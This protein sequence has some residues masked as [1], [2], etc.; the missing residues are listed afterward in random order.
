MAPNGGGSPNLDQRISVQRKSQ[1]P[2]GGGGSTTTWIADGGL[3]AAIEEVRGQERVIADRQAG[4]VTYRVTVH[5]TGLGAEI[6][7][8]HRLVWDGAVLNVRRA[9]PAQ[10]AVY[11]TVEAESGVPT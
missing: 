2:D 4:T 7:T 10:R 6:T 8:T 9:P 11:R 5:N 3:W 1:V